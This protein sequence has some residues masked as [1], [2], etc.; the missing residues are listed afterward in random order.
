MESNSMQNSHQSKNTSLKT[1]DQLKKDRQAIASGKLLPCWFHPAMAVVAAAYVIAP[2]LPNGGPSS[3]GFL[4]GLVATGALVYFA[5]RESG[6][7]FFHG[8]LKSQLILVLM[9][10]V[11][12][13]GI[14]VTFGLV[15]FT[16]NWWAIAPAFGVFVAVLVLSIFYEKSLKNVIIRGR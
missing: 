10:I 2:A 13:A 15:S 11:L 1:V 6:I 12:L 3:S 16:L 14:S 5:Q 4:F 8:S 7:K 9:L